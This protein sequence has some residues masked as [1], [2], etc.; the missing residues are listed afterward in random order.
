M[1]YITIVIDKLFRNKLEKSYKYQVN[2]QL[3]KLEQIQIK[4]T[5]SNSVLSADWIY[6][7]NIVRGT[8]V[9]LPQPPQLSSTIDYT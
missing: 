8:V 6:I 7:G 2:K 4:L 3:L 9:H 1:A 5:L